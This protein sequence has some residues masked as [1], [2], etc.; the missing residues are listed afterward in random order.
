MIRTQV[1]YIWG[2]FAINTTLKIYD[3]EEFRGLDNWERGD[4]ISLNNREIVKELVYL[5]L[6]GGIKRALESP[7]PSIR[8]YV[9]QKIY[10]HLRS[11]SSNPEQLKKILKGR[12][13]YYRLVC[14][15]IF[16]HRNG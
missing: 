10:T 7:T 9:R 14:R 2:G 6:Q 3:D 15:K 11:A 8:R 12:L 16:V 5:G 4:W 1:I 13:I